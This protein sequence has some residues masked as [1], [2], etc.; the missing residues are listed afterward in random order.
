MY[1]LKKCGLNKLKSRTGWEKTERVGSRE[2]P[3]A[4]G[5]WVRMAEHGEGIAQAMTEKCGKC[6]CWYSICHC[7]YFKSIFHPWISILIV[8]VH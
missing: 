2:A 8:L 1:C 7:V 5:L 4:K 6:V 3:K